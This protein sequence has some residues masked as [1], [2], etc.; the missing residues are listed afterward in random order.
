MGFDPLTGCPP[1]AFIRLILSGCGRQDL[2]CGRRG[3][4]RPL[5]VRPLSFVA[6]LLEQ[7][8]RMGRTR[9]VSDLGATRRSRRQVQFVLV[10]LADPSLESWSVLLQGD[11]ARAIFVG[12]K[13]LPGEGFPAVVEFGILEE[14][15]GERASDC[16]MAR[17]RS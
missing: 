12:W 5:V 15:A 16:Q 3:P 17:Y 1:G 10:V 13:G 8:G 2:C 6:A 14:C 11:F 9:S 4:N 7:T